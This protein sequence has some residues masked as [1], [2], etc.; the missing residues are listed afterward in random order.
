M[1][2]AIRNV[3]NTRIYVYVMF[4]SRITGTGGGMI[5]AAAWRG[6]NKR[7]WCRATQT[8]AAAAAGV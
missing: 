3:P 5:G 8:H 1:R 7:Q 4:T 6:S 2:R